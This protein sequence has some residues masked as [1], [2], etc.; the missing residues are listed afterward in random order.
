MNYLEAH[1]SDQVDKL[2]KENYSLKAQIEHFESE[3][4]QYEEKI[5]GLNAK[6]ENLEIDI[7]E[8][9]ELN[10]NLKRICRERANADRGLKPKKQHNG[11]V[12][13]ST[14]SYFERYHLSDDRE[15]KEFLAY[16]TVI[17]T[18]C[19]ANFP[20]KSVL[21][22]LKEDDYVRFLRLGFD[23]NACFGDNDNAESQKVNYRNGNYAFRWNL[24]VS[25][26]KKY[27]EIEVCHTKPLPGPIL[28]LE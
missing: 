3:R 23:W 14:A 17:Q 18:P 19:T 24:K 1:L 9:E 20:L 10:Y 21:V 11:F 12:V 8:A 4:L 22:I 15:T 13:L 26:Q 28:E 25:L 2:E 6:I 5:A 27:W 16:R 7:K